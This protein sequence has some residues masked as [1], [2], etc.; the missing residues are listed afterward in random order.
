[1]CLRISQLAVCITA[2]KE[3]E[4]GV[5]GIVRLGK[6]EVQKKAAEKVQSLL[7]LLHNDPDLDVVD[8]L[9]G[10]L[11]TLVHILIRF[12]LFESF[13]TKLWTVCKAFNKDSSAE[14]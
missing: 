11:T 9:D 14:W 1:M 10:L 6:G 4:D 7:L 5:P 2:K 12:R 8:T 13:P 3:S